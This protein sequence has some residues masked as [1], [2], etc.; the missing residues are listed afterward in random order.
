[1]VLS[2]EVRITSNERFSAIYLI[3]VPQGDYKIG[4][5]LLNDSASVINLCGNIS[6]RNYVPGTP[7][8]LPPRI[9]STVSLPGL[10][11]HVPASVPIRANSDGPPPLPPRTSLVSRFHVPHLH[12]LLPHTSP[13]PV[14][15]LIAQDAQSPRR[16]VMLI[17]GIK[18]HRKIWTTSARPGESIINYTLL[19]NCPAIVLPARPGAP[20]L[21]WDTLT[22]EQIHK[23]QIPDE[24]GG[25]GGEKFKGVVTVL[26]E[27]LDLC[28]EWDR[29][30]LGLESRDTPEN[31]RHAP[32]SGYTKDHNIGWDIEHKR[33][34]M[35]NAITLLLIAAVCS[36]DS[37]EAQK[38]VDVERAG[39]VIFRIP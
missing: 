12:D 33:K 13:T 20:L 15:N 23:L 35:R 14:P 2:L 16:L 5:L 32:R 30:A 22:L 27:Y 39:L 21:A 4:M 1:M 9:N 29:V 31:E 11:A 7:P 24:Q 37:K 25:G 8:P 28:V 6:E 34:V 3:I 38:E 17:V 26:T 10:P 18:P 19:N 36:K